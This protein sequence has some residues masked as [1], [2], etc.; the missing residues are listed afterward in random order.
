MS[1]THPLVR[2]GAALAT[3]FVV[4]AAVAW[5]ALS[6]V[7][8]RP[9]IN[10]HVRWTADVT[11]AQ[12]AQLE[13]RFRRAIEGYWPDSVAVVLGEAGYTVGAGRATRDPRRCHGVSLRERDGRQG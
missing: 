8:P 9:P 5:G 1:P 13:S 4:I 7:R 6:L 11:D 3:A 2:T 10:I 12:R